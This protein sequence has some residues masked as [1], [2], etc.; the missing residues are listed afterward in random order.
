MT[1]FTEQLHYRKWWLLDGR[2]VEHSKNKRDKNEKR[3]LYIKLFGDSGLPYGLW[4]WWVH[5]YGKGVSVGLV[6]EELN[7]WKM[8]DG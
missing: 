6:M 1:D 2:T 5:W 4:I 3:P 8:Y 7:R